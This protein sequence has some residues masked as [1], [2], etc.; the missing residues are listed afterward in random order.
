MEFAP[1]ANSRSTEIINHPA[2]APPKD[3]TQLPRHS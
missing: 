2:S 1:I 3:T